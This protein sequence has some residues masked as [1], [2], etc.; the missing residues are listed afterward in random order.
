M[1]KHVEPRAFYADDLIS[2]YNEIAPYHVA[3]V[4]TR[5]SSG[6][7]PSTVIKIMYL[8]LRLAIVTDTVLY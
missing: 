7:N 3:A 8:R 2:V 1:K 5:A 6:P 4:P